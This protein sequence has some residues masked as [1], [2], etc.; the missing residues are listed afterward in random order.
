MIDLNDAAHYPLTVVVAPGRR[1]SMYFTYH[2]DH[3]DPTLME[4]LGH[5]FMRLL[6]A[7][8]TA[9]DQPV[10]FID[11]LDVRERRQI[12]GEFN[13]T[14]TDY[15]RNRTMMELFAEQ[16][17]RRGEEL[18]VICDQEKISYPNWIAVRTNWDV[19]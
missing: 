13:Q 19:I 12:V 5:R 11:L 10:N 14:H 9:P 18:A 7:Y 6:T 1:L 17:Q 2:P 8:A 15:P 16:V 3:F 4:L